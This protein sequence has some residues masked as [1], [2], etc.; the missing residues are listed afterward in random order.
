MLYRLTLPLDPGITTSGEWTAVLRLPKGALNKLADERE[1]WQ[2]RLEQVSHRGTVPYSLIVQSY[3]DVQLD[4]EVKPSL[5]VAGDTVELVARLSAFGQPFTSRARV[6]VRV[7]G[8]AGIESVAMLNPQ[9][10][11]SFT[12]TLATGDPGVYQLRFLA[13]GRGKGVSRFQREEM[14]TVAAYK[15]EIPKSHGEPGDDKRGERVAQRL[16]DKEAEP[17]TEPRAGSRRKPRPADFGLLEQPAAKPERMHDDGHERPLLTPKAATDGAANTHTTNTPT[18]T[19][20]SSAPGNAQPTGTSSS[21][22]PTRSSVIPAPS[23]TVATP[24]SDPTHKPL[25]PDTNTN[26]VTHTDPRQPPAAPSVVPAQGD[27]AGGLRRSA[28][29]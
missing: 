11:G 23:R 26:T 9:G 1:G 3:S 27:T 10:D 28:C 14:R 13:M 12:G 7:T 19:R 8:P 21:S 24:A 5:C 20:C 25:R 6:S 15:A 16:H 2:Q 18:T 4:A 17:L 29:V 22:H